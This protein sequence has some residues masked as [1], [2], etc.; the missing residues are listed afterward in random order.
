MLHYLQSQNAIPG[1]V[2]NAPNSDESSFH[3]FWFLV[4]EET[5]VFRRFNSWENLP[6]LF[7]NFHVQ[8]L[9]KY[10]IIQTKFE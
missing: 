2:Q 9:K 6:F 1:R 8:L 5:T 7:H 4:H 10:P 3:A